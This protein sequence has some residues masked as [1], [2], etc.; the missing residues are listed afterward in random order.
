MHLSPALGSVS[1][2]TG[3]PG[4]PLFSAFSCLSQT[5]TANFPGPCLPAGHWEGTGRHGDAESRLSSGALRRAWAPGLRGSWLKSKMPGPHSPWVWHRKLLLNQHSAP[6]GYQGPTE[7]SEYWAGPPQSLATG[8]GCL[9]VAMS[10]CPSHPEPGA[11]DSSSAD[12]Q[13]GRVLRISDH[14]DFSLDTGQGP[15]AP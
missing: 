8:V 14:E 15:S 5:L 1:K 10:L 4:Q 3:C 9:D 11:L 2:W 6:G 13:C 12:K 7:H